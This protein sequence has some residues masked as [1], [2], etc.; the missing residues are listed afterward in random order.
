MGNGG[1]WDLARQLANV[2][3]AVFQI[4]A[5]FAASAEISEVTGERTPL[6]EPALYAFSI[7]GLIFFIAG[8]RRLPGAAG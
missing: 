4:G 5:T 6:I 8:L 2:V 3:G 7:W 1:Q